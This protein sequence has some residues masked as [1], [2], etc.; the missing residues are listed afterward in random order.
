MH[1]CMQKSSDCKIFLLSDGIF[2]H[3]QAPIGNLDPVDDRG[4]AGEGASSAILFEDGPV[5][6]PANAFDSRLRGD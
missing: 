6:Y 3:H 1:S 5:V 4:S 2:L